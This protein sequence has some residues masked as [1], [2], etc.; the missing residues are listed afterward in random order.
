MY[1][2]Y[3]AMNTLFT[4]YT[5][6]SML[7]LIANVNPALCNIDEVYYTTCYVH[8]ECSSRHI[9][10]SSTLGPRLLILWPF[11]VSHFC[12]KVCKLFYSWS[13]L[14]LYLHKYHILCCLWRYTIC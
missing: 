1:S 13:L 2:Y 11:R 9:T 7:C 5:T 12:G 6:L 4:W 10:E 8:V 14:Y 3:N